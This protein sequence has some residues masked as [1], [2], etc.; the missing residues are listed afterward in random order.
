[1]IITV[2]RTTTS[3]DEL[4]R[5]RGVSV[6]PN[7]ATEMS[8]SV[9]QLQHAVNYVRFCFW[10]CPFLF[11]HEISREPLSRSA[12]NS[13]GRRVWSLARRSLNVKVKSQRS[14]SP[15]TKNGI[16]RPFGGLRVVY[17]W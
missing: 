3:N 13:H 10:R 7:N 12:P 15:G 2:H 1:M 4:S 8:I 9:Q 6:P 11:V 16:F 17:V 14:T 5:R